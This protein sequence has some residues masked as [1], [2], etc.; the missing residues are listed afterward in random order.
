MLAGS[1]DTPAMADLDDANSHLCIVY[2][3]D[4]AIN[5]LANPILFLPG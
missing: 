2:S 4:D 3:I 1:V 5:P